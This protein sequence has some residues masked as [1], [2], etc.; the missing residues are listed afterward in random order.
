MRTVQSV[1]CECWKLSQRIWNNTNCETWCFAELNSEAEADSNLD[2]MEDS[3]RDSLYFC[4]KCKWC[5][6]TWMEFD[7]CVHFSVY[8]AINLHKYTLILFWTSA[9]TSLSYIYIVYSVIIEYPASKSH[10]L[11][12]KHLSRTDPDKS[13]AAVFIQQTPRCLPGWISVIKI[14]TSMQRHDNSPK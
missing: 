2:G 4:I 3:C 13:A 5:L 8:R 6:V 11:W 1:L 12:L 14:R 10:H 9:A 7:M